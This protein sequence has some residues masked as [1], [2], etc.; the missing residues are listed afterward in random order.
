MKPELIGKFELIINDCVSTN[1]INYKEVLVIEEVDSCNQYVNL[2][3]DT[4]FSLFS[5]FG[6]FDREL[7]IDELNAYNVY[8]TR[9]HQQQSLFQLSE[10]QI[11]VLKE[12]CVKFSKKNKK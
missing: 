6:L 10:H 7:S 3:T 2:A 11:A 4:R 9:K 1:L 8:I 5:S 12:L